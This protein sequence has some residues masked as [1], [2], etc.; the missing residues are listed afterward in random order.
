MRLAPLG[1]DEASRELSDSLAATATTLSELPGF[2]RL[3]AKSPA[4]LKAYVLADDAL[5]HGQ[6]T[7]RER[8]LIALLVGEINGCR[9]SLSA[10]QAL[11]QGLGLS[12]EEIRLARQASAV[13]ARTTALLHFVQTVV[14]QRGD[15]SEED[16]RAV[17]QAGISDAQLIETLA[18]IA[19]N[20]FTDYFNTV[21]Q[22]QTD[23]PLLQPG[24][25]PTAD[26]G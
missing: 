9:Y 10:H 12:D 6:I 1:S 16:F 8:E 26:A 4:A 7:P 3:M 24:A 15:I 17:R 25:A 20:I 11:A 13:D 18:H 5:V 2:L 14:L 23:F 19:L 22:T 21:A